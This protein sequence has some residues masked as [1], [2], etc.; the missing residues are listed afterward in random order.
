MTSILIIFLLLLL[1][2]LFGGCKGMGG[3]RN[4][5]NPLRF[6]QLCERND[7]THTTPYIYGEY[8]TNALCT[9]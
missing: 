5:N 1:V 4:P 2:I 8:N 7:T 3:F 6:E 9:K